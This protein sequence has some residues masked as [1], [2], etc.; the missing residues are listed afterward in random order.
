MDWL[1]ISERNS[2]FR[3]REWIRS[4]HKP[5]VDPRAIFNFEVYI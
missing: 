2:Q 3:C 1:C 4:V 5:M